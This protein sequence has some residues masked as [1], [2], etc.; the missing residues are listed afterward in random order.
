[1]F[2]RTAHRHLKID[3]CNKIVADKEHGFQN[4]IKERI[5]NDILREYLQRKSEEVEKLK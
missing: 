4:A 1:L 2:E 5:K 3:I